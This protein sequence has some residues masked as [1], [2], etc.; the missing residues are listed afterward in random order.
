[1][2]FIHVCGFYIHLWTQ[3]FTQKDTKVS[4]AGTRELKLSK[5][6]CGKKNEKSFSKAK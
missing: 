5:S 4:A 1:M 6:E 2:Y 3:A